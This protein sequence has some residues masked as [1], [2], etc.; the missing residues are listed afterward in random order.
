MLQSLLE[1]FSFKSLFCNFCQKLIH[2][3]FFFCYHCCQMFL[4]KVKLSNGIFIIFVLIVTLISY[5]IKTKL[6][7]VWVIAFFK[8]QLVM[9][10]HYSWIFGLFC[11]NF[12]W[13]RDYLQCAN[14]V[15]IFSFPIESKTQSS[16]GIFKGVFSVVWLR[17]IIFWRTNT[18]SLLGPALLLHLAMQSAWSRDGMLATQ[19]ELSIWTT[20]WFIS[21]TLAAVEP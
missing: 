17:R 8:Y 11:R 9:A 7:G 21:M 2:S 10:C 5:F 6:I 12:G 14:F 15:E 4:W 18:L 19:S 13:W 20:S 3:S 16:L 1:Y